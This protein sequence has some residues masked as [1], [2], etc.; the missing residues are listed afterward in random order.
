MWRSKL[1][2]DALSWDRSYVLIF[3]LYTG[4]YF[5]WVLLLVALYTKY[6]GVIPYDFGFARQQ[7]F[8]Y[9][10]QA[11]VGRRIPLVGTMVIC[12]LLAEPLF[13]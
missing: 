1:I 5:S 9:A 7:N 13:L 6:I 12:S 10:R 2:C 3:V 11:T 8:L 4:T